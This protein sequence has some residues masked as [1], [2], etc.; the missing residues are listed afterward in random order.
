MQWCRA[1]HLWLPFIRSLSC[2][3]QVYAQS[4]ANID[5]R[6]LWTYIPHIP[7]IL[8]A[9]PQ[10]P[11]HRFVPHPR[12][13]SQGYQAYSGKPERYR[14]QD[15]EKTPV[16]PNVHPS[17]MIIDTIN[18][19]GSLKLSR[20]PRP[21]FSSFSPLALISRMELALNTRSL[22]RALAS[23]LG[24]LPCFQS[25]QALWYVSKL[26]QNRFQSFSCVF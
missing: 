17:S 14:D 25:L 5:D 13:E 11:N 20:I 10:Q 8:V 26:D 2:R 4:M 22:S 3:S 9:L 18:P 7:L 16:C 19:L 12:R 23:T 1:D 15:M 24:K 21:G 6:R